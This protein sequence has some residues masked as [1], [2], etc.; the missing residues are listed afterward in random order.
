M[1]ILIAG[2]CG[3]VGSTLAKQF[4]ECGFA[5]RIIGIDNFSRSGSH[6][7]RHDLQR[8]GVRIVYGDIRSTSDLEQLPGV[9]WVI[10]A[11][12]NPSVLAGVDG[13]S[14]SRQLMEHNLWGT[15]QLLEYCKKHQAGMILLST[16]RVYAIADLLRLQ[17]RV[18]QDRFEPEPDQSFPQGIST[19]GISEACSTKPPVSLYG[20]SKLASEQL[21]IEYGATFGFPVWVNRCGLLAGAGQFGHPAQ[22]ICAYWIHSFKEARPL[23]YTGFGGSGHQVRDCLHPRDLVPLMVRQMSESFVDDTDPKPQVINL[24]GGL[25]NQF[26]LSQLT[27]WCQRHIRPMDI[28]SDEGERKFDI[29]WLVLDHDLAS[30]SW[31]WQ[32]TVTLED[33]FQEIAEHADRNPQWLAVTNSS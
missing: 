9:D 25:T 12:A 18:V 4:I 19:D 21:A 29:P 6:L 15:I 30:Q 8:L 10:D 5:S 11:A 26:S 20:S 16:S 13:R 2:I 27:V 3:F 14:S 23:K 17:L 31:Q 24:S 33:I 1:R 7:N 32:P 22:G 28:E